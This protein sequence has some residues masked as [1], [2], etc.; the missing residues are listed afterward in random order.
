MILIIAKATVKKDKLDEFKNT[1][2]KLI[3]NTR[4]EDGCIEYALYENN[5][6]PNILTFVEKWRDQEAVDKHGSTDFFK[7]NIKKIISYSENLDISL[8]TE[9]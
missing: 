7:E 5:E 2:A 6:D 9:V 8:N 4:S 3:K 1:A